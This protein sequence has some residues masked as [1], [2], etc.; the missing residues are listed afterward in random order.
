MGYLENGKWHRGTFDP[1]HKDGKFQRT[2][3]KFR[4]WITHDGS[5]GPSGEGGFKAERDRYHL[6]ISYACPWAHRTLIFRQ[7]KQLED[8]IGISVVDWYMGPEGWHFSDRDGA[9]PDHVNNKDYLREI[10]TL[11]DPNCTGRV[12]V[13]VLWDKQHQT[14]VSNESSEIIRMF[15]SAFNTL[16]GNTQDFCPPN[17]LE[18]IDTI[19]ERIYNTLNNGVYKCGFATTQEAYEEAFDALFET[20]DIME[21]RLSKSRYL[22]GNTLTEADWR[23]FATLIRFDPVYVGH[24][25]CNWKRVTDYPNIHAYMRELYQYDGISELCDFHHIQRHYY[26]SHDSINPNGI[27]P[28]GPS[29]NLEERHGRET[30]SERLIATF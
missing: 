21:D 28:K 22:V 26:V 10:Y 18:E 3:S 30:I 23:A 8:V 14:I 1:K 20:M 25:K 13:P 11:A 16:T 19:N 29:Q 12:T 15:N 24:F 27:V 5:P 7:L 9:I 4:N 6:Y 2:T 17:L